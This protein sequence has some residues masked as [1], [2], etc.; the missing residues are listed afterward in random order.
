MVPDVTLE[1]A[2]SSIVSSVSKSE[3]MVMGSDKLWSVLVLE[4]E[5]E[6]KGLFGN[7]GWVKV[8]LGRFLAS[9]CEQ[10]I[11][12]RQNFGKKKMNGK[13]VHVVIGLE[14]I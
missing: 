13:S 9:N 8:P 6:V 4:L 3:S 7:R 2:T 14:R 12:W 5:V 11:P 10:R 1:A